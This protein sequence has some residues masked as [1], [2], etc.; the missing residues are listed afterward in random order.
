MH[1]WFRVPPW[2]QPTFLRFFHAFFLD[3]GRF[4]PE[5]EPSL[6]PTTK[7]DL[8]LSSFDPD[9]A[10]PKIDDESESKCFHRRPNQKQKP[11]PTPPAPAPA[12]APLV[13]RKEHWLKFIMKFDKIVLCIMLVINIVSPVIIFAL[14][15][16]LQ[17]I[18]EDDHLFSWDQVAEVDY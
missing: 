8:L 7:K 9:V 12:A 11:E 18:H 13:Q 5:T 4:K 17:D 6:K 14:V 2:F 10:M 15:P 3:I 16:H 1:A